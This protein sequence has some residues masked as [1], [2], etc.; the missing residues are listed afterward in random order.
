MARATIPDRSDRTAGAP[1]GTVPAAIARAAKVEARRGSVNLRRGTHR[2]LAQL[3]AAALALLS[4]CTQAPRPAP[5]DAGVYWPTYMGDISRAPFLHQQISSA[6]PNVLWS[7]SVGPALRGMPVVTDKVIVAAS[8]DRNVHTLSRLD[9]STF[10]R[11]KLDGPPVSLL[12]IGDVIYAGTEGKGQ[13]VTLDVIEGDNTWEYKLPSIS[14]PISLVGDT[15]YAATDDGSL[16]AIKPGAKEP[17]WRAFFP[18][19]ASAGPLVLD[20]WVVYVAY[21]SIFLLDRT[22]AERHAAAHSAEIFVGEAASDGETLYLA[23]ELGSLVAWSVPDL[24]F[25][26]QASGFGNFMAGPVLADSIGYAATRT[27]ELVRFDTR[28]GSAEIIGKASGTVL[29][30]PTVVRNGVLLGTVGGRLHFFS[31]N[32][33]PIWDVQLEGSIELPI[34]IHEGRIVVSMYT[35][36]KARLGSGSHGKVVELR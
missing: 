2:L 1:C 6:P 20:G 5:A 32:G 33:E 21:D 11:K 29:A 3:G 14:K 35:R 12:V 17:I 26:W 10:W 9:G 28:R 18:R 34:V 13:L 31:R 27:G 4:G 7:R 15:L 25:L 8:A 22:N 36:G 24:E 30:P 16:F 23:T 19:A